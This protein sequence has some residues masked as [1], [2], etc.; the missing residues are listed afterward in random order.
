MQGSSLPFF[1]ISD[2][3]T[4][5]FADNAPPEEKEGKKKTGAGGSGGAGAGSAAGGSG[6]GAAGAGASCACLPSD[7]SFLHSA[8]FL[9]GPLSFHALCRAHDWP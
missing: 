5:P 7:S 3:S 1:G 8:R 6:G 2:S 4:V 9:S